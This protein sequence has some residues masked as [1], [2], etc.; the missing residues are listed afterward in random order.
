MQAIDKSQT[1][2]WGEHAAA[3]NTHNRVWQLL[4]QYLPQA[5]GLKVLDVP[6]GAGLFAAKLQTLGMDVTG[7]DI[8]HVEP[9]RFD[10]SRRVLANANEG[11][12]FEATRFDAL[13]AIEGIE[14]LENPSLFL[15]ECARVLKPGGLMFLTTPNPDSFRSRRYV[16]FRGH[17]RY[18]HAV[19]DLVKDSGHLLPIDMIF[20]RGACA[21]AGLE[22]VETTVNQ[23]KGRNV[24]TELLR[25]L[26][27]RKLPAYMRG[28]VPFYGEVIIYVLRKPA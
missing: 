11:L 22:V 3:P 10:V 27:T 23:I 7:M 16:M 15:R 17:H 2:E 12:P 14:H 4:N 9:F 5:Q 24:F 6:C 8:A 20:F 13:V 25:G 26:L 21:R 18:F 1:N 28:P 19:N